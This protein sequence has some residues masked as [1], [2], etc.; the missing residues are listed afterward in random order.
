MCNFPSRYD[1]EGNTG[2]H[3]RG[4]RVT[5]CAQATTSR[6]TPAKPKK[7]ASSAAEN[8]LSPKGGQP[9]ESLCVRDMTR[10]SA[11]RTVSPQHT[12]CKSCD[13]STADRLDYIRGSLIVVE[14]RRRKG[15]EGSHGVHKRLRCDKHSKTNEGCKKFSGKQA[16]TEGGQPQESLCARDMTRGSAGRTVSPNTRSVDSM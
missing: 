11:G 5:W 9:Q 12:Q 15:E 8:R 14:R 7:A 13:G 16:V 4:R 1:T 3:W 10:G 6:Q 2:L